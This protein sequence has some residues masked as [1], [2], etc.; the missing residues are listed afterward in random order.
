[1][2]KAEFS[3]RSILHTSKL[4]EFTA[5][6]ASKGWAQEPCKGDYEVLRMRHPLVKEPLLVYRSDKVGR[7][8]YTTYGQSGQ[9]LAAFLHGG[10]DQRRKP[11]APSQS[12]AQSEQWNHDTHA[13]SGGPSTPPWV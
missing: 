10:E 11:Q 3:S 9:L 8:H 4:A 7:E 13:V 1:M 6:C 2:R 5:F 12:S